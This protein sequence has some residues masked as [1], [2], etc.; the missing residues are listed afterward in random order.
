MLAELQHE[1]TSKLLINNKESRT[2]MIQKGVR[3]G[4][5]S[6]PMCFNVIPEMLSRRLKEVDDC[7]IRMPMMS[8]KINHL[9][10]ADDLLLFG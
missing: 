9:L 4:G 3:Q 5:I 8:H 10:F 6:S 7:G 2:F 1:G